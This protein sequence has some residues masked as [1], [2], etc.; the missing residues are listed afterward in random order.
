MTTT[1]VKPSPMMAQWH[2]CKAA[3]KEAILFFRLG[4][5]YEAFYEDAVLCSRELDLTLTK[6]QEVP[7]S[8]IPAHAAE[9]YIDRLVAKG[10]RV[11]IAE[12]LEDPRKT[13]GL[14][15]RDITRVV[16]PGT[17][18]NSSLLV[19]KSNNYFASITQVGNIFGLAFLDLTTGECRVIELENQRDLIS[20]LYRI[21]PAELLT[22][23]KF[24][25]K[26]PSLFEELKQSSPPLLDLID[27]WRFDHQ[28]TYSF[29]KDLLRVHTLDGFGLKGMVAAI[30][31]AGALLAFVQD[32]LLHQIPHI[33]SVIPY[34][35]S[36][37]MGI[38]KV[39][40]K[41]LELTESLQDGKKKNTLIGILDHTSTPMGGR[42]LRSWVKQPL[43]DAG[44][45][46]ARQEAIDYFFSNPRLSESLKSD[47]GQIRDLERL[48][49]RLLTGYASPR[50]MIALKNSL[51]PIARIKC[52]LKESSVPFLQKEERTLKDLSQIVQ[53]IQKAIVDEPPLRISEG[54]VFRE[55]Y[56]TELD[57]LRRITQDSKSWMNQYQTAIRENTGIKTL[58][59]GFTKVSGFYIEV[60]RGQAEKVPDIFLRRQT[61]TNAERFITPELKQFEEKYLHAEENIVELEGRLFLELRQQVAIF[62]ED[63]L[64]NAHSLANIDSILSLYEAAK[65]YRYVKPLVD[66]SLLL[67]IKEGRHPVIEGAI[68]CESFIPND[69]HLDGENERL[70]LITGPNMAGKSTYI[71]QTALIVIMAQ[72]G[73]Y[74][75]AS[76]A[77]MGIVDKI[78]S[79]IGASDDLSRGQSTFMVEMTETA[80]ILH[81]ATPRSLIILDEIGRGTSTYDGISIA[82]SIAEYLLTTSEK[83]AKTLF[84]THYFELTKL[85]EQFPGAVNYNVAVHESGDHIVFLRKIVRGGADKSYG[86]HVARLAGLPPV[87]ISRAQEILIHLEEKA[88]QRNVF[89]PPRTKKSISSKTKSTGPDN[90]LHFL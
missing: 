57:E 83:T 29:L 68:L 6:R 85:E 4:D 13:K 40:A 58:K 30:N 89:D 37:F 72:M 38:D 5:F 3:S 17:V 41:N 31:A 1:D 25:E 69:V 32:T 76:Y 28:F 21:A 75:P 16:T 63:I 61:L 66:D 36:E 48:M 18:I 79:R 45:I 64:K 9:S 59:V 77:H 46:H 80:T 22:S 74:V 20:E 86:I 34:S 24:K 33:Q 49:T 19:E 26:H 88:N 11:A 87:V 73:S 71:R 39:T 2:Q 12:Q 14:V 78:F 44:R 67:D 7:M 55:G 47:L 84:A 35:K 43:L 81:H 56:N 15:K 60:S 10:Y 23:H 51:E 65:K 70:A 52:S 50:D 8:G 54:E 27:D 42:L 82:W 90:Q 53:L 62:S